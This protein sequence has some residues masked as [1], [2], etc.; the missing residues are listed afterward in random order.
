VRQEW[1]HA[2]VLKKLLRSTFTQACR[3]ALAAVVVGMR[4]TVEVFA[5][6][7]TSERSLNW[8][9]GS[10]EGILTFPQ[11][12]SPGRPIGRCCV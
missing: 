10:F 6:F 12:A 2:G 1:T 7:K 11:G 9:W 5:G 8:N 4:G 3:K